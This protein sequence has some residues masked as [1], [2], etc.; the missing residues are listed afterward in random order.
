MNVGDVVLVRRGECFW[1]GV[2]TTIVSTTTAQGTEDL[3]RV[4]NTH[5]SYSEVPLTADVLAKVYSTSF[6]PDLMHEQFHAACKL[7]EKIL[8]PEPI[9]TETHPMPG[10]ELTAQSEKVA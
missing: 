9:T 1:L 10:D 6:I 7:A 3:Y 8:N 5:P 4:R 2:V